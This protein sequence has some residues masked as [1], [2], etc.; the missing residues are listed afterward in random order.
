ML[1]TERLILRQWKD[2]DY[3]VYAE[4]TADPDVMSY[5]PST[6]SFEQGVEQAEKLRAKI[7]E[8][9]WGF[10]AIELKETHQFIGFI[11]LGAVEADSNIPHAPMIE[12]A[13]RLRADHWKQ[14]YATEGAMRAIKFAFE[15][16]DEKEV[17]SFTALMNI[18]S[19]R[20]MIKVGMKNTGEDFDHPKLTPGEK[21]AR[22]CLYRIKHEEWLASEAAR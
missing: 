17:Y 20:V 5:F 21:L 19:Q 2:E 15:V 18:P 7:A 16:L 4:M 12:I 13:W 1:E 6:L 11:G 9:G 3:P 10:W 14:G 22:H 8:R